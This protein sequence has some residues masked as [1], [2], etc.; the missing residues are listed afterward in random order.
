MTQSSNDRI[1]LAERIACAAH[2]HQV[3]RAGVAYME[4]VRSVARAVADRGEDYHIVGLLHD[5]VEDCDDPTIVSLPM[6]ADKFGADIAAGVDAITKR[7]G[8]DYA[9]DYIPR[10]LANPLARVVKRADL[11]HN[12]GRLH[13]LPLDQQT[14]LRKKYEAVLSQLAQMSSDA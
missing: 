2:E 11:A 12:L 1:A 10:L 8:E 5:T 4:H 13:Q 9:K 3:D 6:I 7:D 14:K